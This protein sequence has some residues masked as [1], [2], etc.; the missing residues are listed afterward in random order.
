MADSANLAHIQG[1]IYV[2]VDTE[3]Q[4]PVSSPRGEF[5]A[6][7]E[8]KR[9]FGKNVRFGAANIRRDVEQKGDPAKT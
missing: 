7:R 3:I 8:A 6:R 5:Y 4:T 2:F 1:I 9:R